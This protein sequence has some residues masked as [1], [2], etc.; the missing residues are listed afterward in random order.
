MRERF[1][2]KNNQEN[3]R[4]NLDQRNF[5]NM[6]IQTGSADQTTL[7]SWPTRW[8]SSQNSGGSKALRAC[9]TYD[10]H[11]KTTWQET[12]KSS[13]IGTQ[14]MEKTRKTFKTN[15]KKE[16]VCTS[17]RKSTIESSHLHV[18]VYGHFSYIC[19]AE[20]IKTE[21]KSDPILQSSR[22][23]AHASMH[24]PNQQATN[25]LPQPTQS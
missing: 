14:E 25:K 7:S 23:E 5:P 10:T 17:T 15:S 6:G 9:T 11:R 2:D 18:P 21:A 13:L 4:D 19:L 8:K 24:R 1:L 20:Y 12:A 22:T 3:N 16:G